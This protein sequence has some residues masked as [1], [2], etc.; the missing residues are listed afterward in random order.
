MLSYID[1]GLQSKVH[2]RKHRDRS[3]VLSQHTIF[4]SVSK[5]AHSFAFIASQYGA[6]CG[7]DYTGN[8][9]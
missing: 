5:I 8:S 9:E 7:T 6:P 1:S 4:I 2:V 3:R